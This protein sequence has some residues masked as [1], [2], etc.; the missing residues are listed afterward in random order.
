VSPIESPDETSLKASRVFK[1]LPKSIIFDRAPSS[2]EKVSRRYPGGSLLL[3]LSRLSGRDVD[4]GKEI[5]DFVEGCGEDLPPLTI[6]NAKQD[7]RFHGEV[8]LFFSPH[9]QKLSNENRIT[10][11][12]LDICWQNV[13]ENAQHSLG[14]DN[15][16]GS[17]IVEAYNNH[18]F[19][20]RE[21]S[22][23]SAIIRRSLR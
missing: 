20:E 15:R 23:S 7:Y 9:I 8:N 21:Q 19:L 13:H 3:G 17:H 16:Y 2:I 11:L 18:S 4:V 1:S 5:S 10:S 6:I 12:L 22:L 14:L